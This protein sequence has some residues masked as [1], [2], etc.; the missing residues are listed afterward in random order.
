MKTRSFLT[1]FLALHCSAVLRAADAPA[2]PPLT[3]FRLRAAFPKYF[4]AD[5][6]FRDP[7][8]VK[9][10]NFFYGKPANET[11][12]IRLDAAKPAAV[13]TLL[14]DKMAQ[15]KGDQSRKVLGE[16]CPP[17][18]PPVVTLTIT[19]MGA[20]QP[21]ASGAK[22]KSSQT[23]EL[24]GTLEIGGRKLP[25][26]ASTKLRQ[27]NGKGDE[28]NAALMLDGRFTLKAADLGLK[29]IAADAPIEIR[30]SL[31]AYPPQS[32]GAPKK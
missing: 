13:F 9:W 32:A 27:H 1:L 19:A 15:E 18:K 20:I 16:L 25:V 31:S 17:E 3:D 26:K 22:D 4:T 7:T 2:P 11:G 14:C 28:K 6:E 12:Y 10:P 24:T 5:I 21:A 29:A 23:T 8:G 30:F